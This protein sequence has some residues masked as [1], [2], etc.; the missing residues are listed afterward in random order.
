MEKCPDGRLKV[1]T[2]EGV[3]DNVDTLIWAIGR[4]PRTDMLKLDKV[5]CMVLSRSSFWVYGE[6][7]AY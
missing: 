1:M 3:L 6:V 5:V 7:V 2:S 4:K